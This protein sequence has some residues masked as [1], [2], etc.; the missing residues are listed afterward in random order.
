MIYLDS[1]Q[2]FVTNTRFFI[3]K[4]AMKLEVMGIKK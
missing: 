3:I 1:I 2:N 4:Y